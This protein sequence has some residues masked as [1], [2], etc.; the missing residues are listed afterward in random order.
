MIYP[1][2][3]LFFLIPLLIF[4]K[5]SFANS[6]YFSYQH[7]QQVKTLEIK[8]VS[9]NRFEVGTSSQTQL[10][11]VTLDWPPYIDRNICG[12]GWVFQFTAALFHELGYSISVEFFPWARFVRMAELGQADILF[13]EYFIEVTAP[14]DVIANSFRINN[15]A[16]SAPYAGGLVGLITR[17][18]FSTPYDGT[19]KTIQGAQIG[20]V[21]GYQNTPEFDKHLDLGFFNAIE[22][23]DDAQNLKML[24]AGRVDYIVADPNVANYLLEHS[25]SEY[26]N[27][28]KLVNP[29]F[30]ENDFYF[31]I[32]KKSSQWQTLQTEINLKL[33]E[34][35][36]S[37]TLASIQQNAA[38]CSSAK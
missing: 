23:R 27:T 30:Q 36:D 18:D 11:L 35:I 16:L 4:S 3:L 34:F 31:A 9:T 12:K 19:F 14:S 15:L 37:G 7:Q 25:K 17:D 8:Q 26:K 28:I 20:V 24:L 1:S 29:P 6:E 13:P 32:S 33:A 21:R 10:R 2:R 38:N 5:Q 22:A